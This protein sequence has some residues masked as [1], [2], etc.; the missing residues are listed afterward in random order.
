MG[1]CLGAPVY[2]G[3][4]TAR[5][6]WRGP[7]WTECHELSCLLYV[8][9]PRAWGPQ[10]SSGPVKECRVSYACLPPNPRS[11]V[12]TCNLLLDGD[13]STPVPHSTHP[14][15]L[16]FCDCTGCFAH[17]SMGRNGLQHPLPGQRA[18]CMGKCRIQW[19]ESHRGGQIGPADSS[20]AAIGRRA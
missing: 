17:S 9:G 16:A 18:W 2:R 14:D 4:R 6:R 10:A 7:L 11:R 13:E 5:P 15:P 20:T 3:D 19:P 12:N 8:P 1:Y